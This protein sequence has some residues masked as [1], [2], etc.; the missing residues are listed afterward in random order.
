MPT[1]PANAPEIRNVL[2]WTAPMLI[3]PA[4]AEPGEEPTARASY[5]SRVRF[6]RNQTRIEHPMPIS[7]KTFSG[8]DRTTPSRCP[9]LGDDAFGAK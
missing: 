8:T 7:S 4:R 2:I 6:K 9:M 5:P 1:I 3:P